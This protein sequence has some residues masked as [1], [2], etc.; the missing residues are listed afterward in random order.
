[1]EF[2][3]KDGKVRVSAPIVE[4]IS[5]DTQ[6]H[7]MVSYVK[8]VKDWFKDNQLKDGDIQKYY[9]T[10]KSAPYG[11]TQGLLVSLFSFRGGDSDC[12]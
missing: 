2:R 12:F 11:T 3:I 6:P 8:K 1:M 5:M 4:E 7:K 9:T 10:G